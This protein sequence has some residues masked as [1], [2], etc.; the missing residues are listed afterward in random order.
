MATHHLLWLHINTEG[1]ELEWKIV[2]TTGRMDPS[3]SQ[4]YSRAAWIPLY[5]RIFPSIDSLLLAYC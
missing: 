2:T 3:P 1:G 4:S 5:Y